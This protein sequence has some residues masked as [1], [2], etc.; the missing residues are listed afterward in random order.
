[1]S[2]KKLIFSAAS[3]ILFLQFVVPLL[4]IDSVESVMGTAN[5]VVVA[6]FCISTSGL[7]AEGCISLINASKKFSLHKPDANGE[8]P[9]LEQAPVVPSA[10]SETTRVE[11]KSVSPSQVG[12]SKPS[13]APQPKGKQ[14]KSHVDVL[15]G[16]EAVA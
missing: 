2:V 3:S 5:I 8:L 15:L 4:G 6:G 13:A 10:Q 7:I 11:P 16:K 9:E 12:A 1:M 14:T